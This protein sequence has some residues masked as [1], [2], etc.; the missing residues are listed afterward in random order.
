MRSAYGPG[1]WLVFRYDVER[2]RT[3]DTVTG[4]LLVDAGVLG[5]LADLGR[6]QEQPFLIGP[7]GR[8]DAGVNAFFA[9]A[10][11]VP[12]QYVRSAVGLLCSLAPVAC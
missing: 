7:D 2:P 10:R 4:R 9:S 6:R 1:R 11:L 12:C 3:L 5:D 8:P